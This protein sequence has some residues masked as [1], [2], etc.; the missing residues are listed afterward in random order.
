MFANQFAKNDGKLKV[1]FL[2]PPSDQ[3]KSDAF[4]IQYGQEI[5]TVDGGMEGTHYF[6]DYLMKTRAEL[7]EG[8]PELI[9]DT[10]C[11]LRITCII[12]HFHTDHVCGLLDDVIPNEYIS[13]ST[14]YYG[15][16]LNV[17]PEINKISRN[18]DVIYRARLEKIIPELRP[19]CKLIE[20]DFGKEH[21]LKFRTNSGLEHEVEFTCLPAS[22]DWS[23][24]ERY[25]YMREYYD[26]IEKPHRTN[27]YT[28]NSSSIWL[29]I[30]LGKNT[31]LFTGDTI[32]RR[33]DLCDEAL[34]EMA[35]LYVDEYSPVTVLKYVHHGIKREC[36]VKNMLKF[37]PSHIVFTSSLSTAQDD[38]KERAPEEYDSI[39]Y[40]ESGDCDL[41]A[42]CSADS[43]VVFTQS[44]EV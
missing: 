38:I 11:K 16:P 28:I 30:R 15:G 19:D 35:A 5:F 29:H 1:A 27:V 8:H 3:K 22:A 14:I 12:S 9:E 39:S 31:F 26:I 20:V 13:I 32:K 40:Y 37:K 43:D 33:D 6:N 23:Q 25:E 41:F 17:D 42:E 44:K 21:M 10:S 36:A 18:G 24:G 7:L 34:D 4:V 2:A